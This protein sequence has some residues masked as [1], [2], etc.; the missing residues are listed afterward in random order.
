MEIK[1]SVMLEITK[2]WKL[3]LVGIEPFVNLKPY[4]L[5]YFSRG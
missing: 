1:D 3:P 5:S 4:F 2:E